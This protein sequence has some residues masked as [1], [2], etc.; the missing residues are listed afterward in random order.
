MTRTTHRPVYFPLRP[1]LTAFANLALTLSLFFQLVNYPAT[2]ER[3]IVALS[4][5]P[6]VAWLSCSKMSDHVQIIVCLTVDGHVSF[7]VADSALQA[8]ALK[9]AGSTCGVR[10][11]D[12]QLS[13]LRMLPYLAVRLEQLET[14]LSTY[15]AAANRASTSRSFLTDAQLMASIVAARALS[16]ALTKLPTGI[17]LQIDARTDALKVMRLLTLFQRQHIY[18]LSLITHCRA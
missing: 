6:Q 8:A 15:P 5:T 14:N 17:Y 3:G 12:S 11:S 9:Q 16:P 18:R 10:F 2:P 7:A 1:E 4:A 13:V